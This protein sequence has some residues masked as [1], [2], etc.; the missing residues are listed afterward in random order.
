MR[1]G[2]TAALELGQNMNTQLSAIN[3]QIAT[4]DVDRDRQARMQRELDELRLD[5]KGLIGWR[6]VINRERMR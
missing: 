4:L 2:V 1:K 6:D 5:V 3:Q